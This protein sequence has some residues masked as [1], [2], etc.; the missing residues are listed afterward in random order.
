[1]ILNDHTLYHALS[2]V[3]TKAVQPSTV[4]QVWMWEAKTEGQTRREE[5]RIKEERN[6]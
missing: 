6:K 1:M 2:M 3:A 4:L 5:R